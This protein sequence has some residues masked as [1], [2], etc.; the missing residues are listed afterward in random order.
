MS[1]AVR[2]RC[3]YDAIHLIAHVLPKVNVVWSGTAM[4]SLSFISMA[5]SHN[6]TAP[7]VQIIAGS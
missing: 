6:C 4:A 3:W 1:C 7:E 2:L 5:N